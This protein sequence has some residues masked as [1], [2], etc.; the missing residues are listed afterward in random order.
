MIRGLAAQYS[1]IANPPCVRVLRVPRVCVPAKPVNQ[2]QPKRGKAVL[3]PSVMDG[4]PTRQ[5][6]RTHH[7]VAFAL[8]SQCLRVPG[9]TTGRG[10]GFMHTQPRASLRRCFDAPA[11][12]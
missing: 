5:D 11:E 7:Q 4:D 8:Y 12:R 10:H 3:W 2:V 1:L 6:P 9:A